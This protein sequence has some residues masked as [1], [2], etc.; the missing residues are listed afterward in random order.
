MKENVALGLELKGMKKP[1]RLA[2]AEKYLDL[3]GLKGFEHNYPYELS[4]ACGRG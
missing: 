2:A 1:D 4:G 3:V